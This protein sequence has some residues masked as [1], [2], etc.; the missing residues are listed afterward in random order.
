MLSCGILIVPNPSVGQKINIEGWS[1]PDLRGLTPYSVTIKEVSG[2]EKM[3]EKFYTPQG[4]HIARISGNGKVYGYAVDKDQDPPIDYLLLDLEGSGK[5]TLKLGP[6][7]SYSLP[8]W[9][10]K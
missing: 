2:V 7:D 8:E 6:E 9:I 4:G 5:F 3:I 1:I 10:L